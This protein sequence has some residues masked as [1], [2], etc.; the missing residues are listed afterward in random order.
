MLESALFGLV[1]M[2]SWKLWDWI[3]PNFQCWCILGQGWM[4]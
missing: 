2:M 3:S 1:N 4:L